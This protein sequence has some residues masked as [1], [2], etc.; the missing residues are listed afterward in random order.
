MTPCRCRGV[1]L[2]HAECAGFVK[3]EISASGI[4]RVEPFQH[5]LCGDSPSADGGNVPR[6]AAGQEGR[7]QGF[8]PLNSH[9]LLFLSPAQTRERRPL[10]KGER[11]SG[12]HSVSFV[13]YSQFA[14]SVLLHMSATLRRA[15]HNRVAQFLGTLYRKAPANLGVGTVYLRRCHPSYSDERIARHC[16]PP[17]D[18][19][20]P[21]GQFTLC[22]ACVDLTACVAVC[23]LTLRIG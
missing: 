12:Y 18:L 8:Y 5:R 23:C 9:F 15:R 16:Y 17:G 6:P 3:M 14:D 19:L 1:L 10:R 13:K 21:F 20:L 2:Y 7:H 11:Q 22:R 4:F